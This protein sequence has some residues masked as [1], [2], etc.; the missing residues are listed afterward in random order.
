MAAPHSELEAA[1]AQCEALAKQRLE[2]FPVLSEY[3]ARE[4]SHHL[5]AVY[6]FCRI[7][8]DAADESTSPEEALARLGALARD[9]DRAYRGERAERVEM[10]ALAAT[11]ESRRLPREPFDDL[12]EA[13]RQDQHKTRYATIGELLDY[14][15]RSADPVG[16]LVLETLDQLRDGRDEKLRLSSH[17]CTGLQLANFWQDVAKDARKGRIYLPADAMA[18]H[19][20]DEGTIAAGSATPGFRA[21]LAELC[22][23]TAP[24]FVEGARLADLVEGRL[25][26]PILAFA[27]AG[28]ELLRRI[29]EADYDVFAR[30]PEIGD[31][32]LKKILAKA[33]AARWIPAL[34]PR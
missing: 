10:R 21:L 29:R 3:V 33:A 8:D 27:I 32:P 13:F 26:I 19:G 23:L 6:A 2:N 25:R 5:A 30:R 34:R 16:R 11:I 17:V 4:H 12:L 9:L 24:R 28:D 18:R 1:Y 7:A 15:R 14:S 22:A 31:L 20:V